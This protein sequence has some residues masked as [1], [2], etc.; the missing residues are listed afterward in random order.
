MPGV[1][2]C[3]ANLTLTKVRFE[4]L[5]KQGLRNWCNEVLRESQKKYVP[6]ATGTLRR[7]GRVQEMKLSPVEYNMRISY[8][9]NYAI[10]VHEIPM[11]HDV[12]SMKFLA[13]PFNLMSYRL[14][15]KLEDAMEAAV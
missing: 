2:Q 4:K 10:Y 1:A 6:V 13:T 15:K 12:G 14:I 9:V 5:G 8:T 7:S 11:Q 3:L